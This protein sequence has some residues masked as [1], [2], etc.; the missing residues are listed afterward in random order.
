M[1]S[2]II[3]LSDSLPCLPKS[4]MPVTIITGFLGSGKTTLLNHILDNKRKIIGKKLPV[5]K[6][7]EFLTRYES[8]Q[9]QGAPP[10]KTQ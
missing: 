2:L 7:E 5:E 6:L 8:F 10:S 3:P 9:K 4:G 1:S